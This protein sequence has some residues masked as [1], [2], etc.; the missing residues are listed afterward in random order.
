MIIEN[1]SWT[2]LAG[3]VLLALAL[4]V[5][6][7]WARRVRYRRTPIMTANEREFY[8]RLLA[9]FPD[10]EIWP[11]VPILALLRPDAKEGSRTFWIAFKQ[12]SNMRVDWVIARDLEV[13]AVIELDDRSHDAK[14]DARRD[15]ILKSCGYR[16][17]R[18]Q[19]GKRPEPE[20]IHEAVFATR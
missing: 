19:S 17:L 2:W 18:F 3:I 13:I 7:I 8:Q 20:Q 16:V 9:A 15:Q 1:M 10:C 6:L 5:A 4:I 11:Q 14:R 12:I